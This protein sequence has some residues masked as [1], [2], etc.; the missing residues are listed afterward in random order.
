MEV[1]NFFARSSSSL[2]PPLLMNF[3][4][5]KE[6]REWEHGVIF[7]PFVETGQSWDQKI[8]PLARQDPAHCQAITVISVLQFEM[9]SACFSKYEDLNEFGSFSKGGFFLALPTFSDSVLLFKELRWGGDTPVPLT[10]SL[11][12]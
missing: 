2:T 1:W 7:I 4:R 5:L 3:L 8:R 11:Y 12:L 9:Y 10:G 6:W